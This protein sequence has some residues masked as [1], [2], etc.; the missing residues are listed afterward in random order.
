MDKVIE[1]KN[2]SFNYPDG[3]QGLISVN[4]VVYPGEN[5]AVIGPNGAGKST[6]LLHLN[7]I[8]RGNSTVKICG[9]AVEEKKLK[10]IRKKVGLVFQ[11]PEDQLFSLNVFDDVAF[12]PIN[13]GY[14]ESEVGQRVAQA[15]EWV[16][17]GGYEQRSPHHLSVGEKKRIAIATVLSLAPEVLVIDEPTSNLD[18]RSK[19]SLIELLKQLPMTKIIATH[20]LEL[21]RA[22][23]GRIVV[24][25]EGKIVADGDK[26][27][28]L[29]DIRLLKTY[30]LAH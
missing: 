28:I 23:C 18:P 4:L 29:D 17:M 8:L 13:M 6:L 27:D 5:V 7:G 12:G 25:D 9:L 22:L 30:G 1:I 26:G 16:E 20:D 24:M 3:H 19:W 2:L 15:L 14:A 11:N 21:V 10:E